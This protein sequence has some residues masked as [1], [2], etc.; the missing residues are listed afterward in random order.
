MHRVY[1]SIGSNLGDPE[2][3]IRTALRKI[4]STAGIKV[5][6]VSSLYLTEPVGFEDQP[7]FH[8]CVA[9]LNTELG[10]QTLLE[11]LQQIENDLGRVRT[12]RWGPRTLDL[13]I[14]LFDRLQ[15]NSESLTIPH[16]RMKERSF[17]MVPLGEI[18][19]DAVFPDGD[20]V[21][22]AL[23]EIADGK[24]YCCIPQKIW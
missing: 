18:A 9:E 16:P 22:E 13:D 6:N 24:K 11:A 3:N 8:N 4:D 21:S 14:L 19:P 7:W 10:P 17:V 1:I 2:H 23:K 15:I 20:L 12:V 5:V